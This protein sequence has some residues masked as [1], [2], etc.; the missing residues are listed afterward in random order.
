MKQII[1]LLAAVL[2]ALPLQAQ[3]PTTLNDT[4]LLQLHHF[5]NTQDVRSAN[6]FFDRLDKE[7][8]TDHRIALPAATPTDT[9]RA[10]VW[11]WMQLERPHKAMV[12][13]SQKAAAQIGLKQYAEAN[14][15]LLQA[16]DFFRTQGGQRQSLGICLNKRGEALLGLQ[17]TD[18]AKACYR[19]A[20]SL[21]QEIGDKNNEMHARQG[22]YECLYKTEPDS[23]KMEMGRFVALRDSLYDLASAESLAR[24]NAEFGNKLLKQ[25]KE[26]EAHRQRDCRALRLCRQCALHPRFQAH[27]PHDSFGIHQDSLTQPF[28]T[29]APLHFNGASVAHQRGLHCNATEAPLH[30]NRASVAKT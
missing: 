3:K 4:T 7:E 6:Q 8:F 15:V 29:G 27:F 5:D 11:Y 16:I 21:F 13:L 22:L 24:Y 20:A 25:E 18:E 12:R 28:S 30:H 17:R 19:E 26:A 2:I 23:A 1:I 10:L 14:E 9:L